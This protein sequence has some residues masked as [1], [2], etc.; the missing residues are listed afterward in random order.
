MD[1]NDLQKEGSSDLL[2]HKSDDEEIAA[3]VESPVI[4]GILKKLEPEER[5]ILALSSYSGPLPPPE[6]LKGYVEVYPEAANQIFRWA[7]DEQKH[8][9][10]ME[11]ESLKKSFRYNSIGLIGGIV[12]SLFF[13]VGGF[14]LIILDKDVLGVSVIAPFI[15]SLIT[16]VVRGKNKIDK[17]DKEEKN[18]EEEEP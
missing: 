12:L 15:I 8:R 17:N 11:K 9:H 6:Y 7:E 14:I 10:Y 2:I 18:Y 4:E 1:S 3:T 5:E 13:I 16:L